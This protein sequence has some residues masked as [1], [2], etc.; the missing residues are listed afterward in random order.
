MFKKGD[1]IRRTEGTHMGMHVGDVGT[2]VKD[3]GVGVSI[4]EYGNGS[5]HSS[6]FF[7]LVA[8]A[9]D[10]KYIITMDF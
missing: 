1:R 2:V 4:K 3:F 10:K 8:G 5:T 9:K 7:E 6:R